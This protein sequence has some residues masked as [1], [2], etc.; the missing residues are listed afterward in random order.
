MKKIG[1]TIIE[2]GID[3]LVGLKSRKTVRA[4]ILDKNNEENILLLYSKMFDDYTF[5]G[6]GVK[7]DEFYEETIKRELKEELGANIV[8]V[9]KEIGYTEEIRF[10]VNG[11]NSKYKQISYY[12]LCEID[13]IGTPEFVGREM[14]QGLE[15]KWIN[16]DEA[17]K[18]NEIINRQERQ[19]SK[20]FKTVLIRE[21]LVLNYIKEHLL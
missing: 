12:L 19:F 10:G 21:N 3:K 13:D 8:K 2:S 18:H 9:I 15:S 17:I 14:I 6:G 11:T 1:K 4:I 20:G 5:P 7:D 16:I